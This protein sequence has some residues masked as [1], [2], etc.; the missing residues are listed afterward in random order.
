M[1][2]GDDQDGPGGLGHTSFDAI[3]LRARRIVPRGIERRMYGE[4]LIVESLATSPDPGRA[5]Y[6]VGNVNG[7]TGGR[8]WGRGLSEGVDDTR[9]SAAGR[10]DANTPSLAIEGNP[11]VHRF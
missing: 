8:P 6:F 2:I 4:A 1:D 9:M 3:G 10:A 11:P 7:G 5:V